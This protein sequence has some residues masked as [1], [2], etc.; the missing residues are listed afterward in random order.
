[1]YVRT[2]VCVVKRVTFWKGRKAKYRAKLCPRRIERRGAATMIRR[3]CS[4]AN[5][6]I[7]A[8][9]CP[10]RLPLD[11]LPRRPSQSRQSCEKSIHKSSAPVM[12][13]ICKWDNVLLISPDSENWPLWKPHFGWRQ[14]HFVRK[15]LRIHLPLRV[16]PNYWRGGGGIPCSIHWHLQTP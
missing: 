6:Q 10:K 2:W 11:N 5:V 13:F 4:L 1:M 16:P 7:S 3:S 9:K 12:E 15:W 8:L 14:M